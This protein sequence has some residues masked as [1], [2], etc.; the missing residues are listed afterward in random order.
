ML[1]MR[2]TWRQ[3]VVAVIL[4]FLPLFGVSIARSQSF[5]L[6][7][8]R[9]LTIEDSFSTAIRP[10]MGRASATS[11]ES[12]ATYSS[13]S[14]YTLAVPSQVSDGEIGI[15]GCMSWEECRTAS[16]GTMVYTIYHGGTVASSIYSQLYVVKRIFF[17]FDTSA[18]PT[19]ATILSASL[20]F[21]AGS[22]QNGTTRIHAVNAFQSQVL[23]R[24]DFSRV[25]NIS[26][27]FVDLAPNTWAQIPLNATGLSWIAKGGITKIALVH[28]FDLNNLTPNETNDSIISM[29]ED[30]EHS[31]YLAVQYSAVSINS[32]YLPLVA[33][34]FL[35]YFEG[36]YEVEPNNALAVANGPLRS[37][38]DYYGYPNDQKDYFS[39]HISSPGTIHV[40]GNN[41][42]GGDGQ[43]QLFY[44]TNTTPPV[45]T[46]LI[47]PFDIIYAG[48]PGWY[49]IY[50]STGTNWS[51]TTPYT[52]RVTYP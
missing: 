22:F 32:I 36:P 7:P 13:T 28:H 48:N 21:Y 24:S 23:E 30:T 17:Y 49:Y 14:V 51:S 31:P 47:P 15:Q 35:S 2:P 20:N 3:L 1:S 33:N 37:G 43:M 10:N 52:L 19:G 42:T 16:Q 18:L 27:G 11:T 39:F 45:I 8:N 9:P 44:E 5:D 46:D 12:P 34:E 41:Y 38:Q 25:G 4:S 50:I 29:S 26:G 40:T 6:Q